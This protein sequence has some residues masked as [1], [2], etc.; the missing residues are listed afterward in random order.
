MTGLKL[1]ENL[2]CRQTGQGF[3][4][5]GADVYLQVVQSRF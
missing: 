5:V 1:N 2:E 3:G 4:G